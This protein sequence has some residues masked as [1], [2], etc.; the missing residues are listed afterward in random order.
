M[1]VMEKE[2]KVF[3]SRI[4]VL[5]S[6]FILATLSLVSIPVLRQSSYEGLYILGGIFLF[7]VLL[8]TGMSYVISGNKLYSK[9]WSITCASSN[10]ADIGSV[11]RTYNPLS[12]PAASLK[13]LEIRFK[14][15][16]LFW[17]ISPVRG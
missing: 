4:S 15:G 9:T 2:K 12:S 3:R 10:I 6:V 16:S 11:R 13:R 5:L 17:L 1:Q 8:F 7:I 14:T